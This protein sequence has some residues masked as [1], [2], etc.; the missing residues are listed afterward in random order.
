MVALLTLM[1]YSNFLLNNLYSIPI[2]QLLNLEKQYYE[3]LVDYWYHHN[4]LTLQWWLLVAL[5]VLPPIIWWL[6][7]NKKEL[8]EITTFGLFYGMAAII[9]DSIGNS[10]M[11]W[12]YPVRLSPYLFPQLYPYDVGIVI[13]PFMLVYQKWHKNLKMFLLISGVLSAFL[14]FIAEPFME[15]FNIYEEIKWH[16]LYSFPIYWLLSFVCW[17]IIKYFKKKEQEG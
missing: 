12:S 13:I 14:A 16:H 8:I 9:F 5:T 15:W 3:K 7:V 4:F 10:A 17:G 11:I 1:Q 6:F 2:D